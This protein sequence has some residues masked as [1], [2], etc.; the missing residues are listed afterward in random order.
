[1]LIGCLPI[2]SLRLSTLQC[3]YDQNCLDQVKNTLNIQNISIIPLNITQSSKFPMNITFNQVIDN[4]MLEKW[5]YDV[6]Y[7]KYFSECS[8]KQCSYSIVKENNALVIFTT[9]LGLCKF[10]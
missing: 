6:D 7:D 9:L 2:T 8:P 5:T 4:L 1:M 10:I 3:F